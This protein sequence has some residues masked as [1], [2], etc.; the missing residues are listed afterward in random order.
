WLDTEI[1]GGTSIDIFNRT[2]N[3][4]NLVAVKSSEASACVVSLAD[5]QTALTISNAQNN[6]FAL[7]GVCT[8]A[9]MAG[10]GTVFDGATAVGTNAFGGLVSDGVPVG[11]DGKELPNAPHWTISLGAE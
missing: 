11:L 6:P 2:Q 5:A 4:P 8:P 3:N 1:D 10:V 7:L 9:S